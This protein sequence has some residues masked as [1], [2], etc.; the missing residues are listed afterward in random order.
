MK[1]SYHMKGFLCLNL[2]CYLD[3]NSIDLV[4]SLLSNNL[5]ISTSLY[6]LSLT[7][8]WLFTT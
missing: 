2:S 1:C 4:D 6:P 5:S 8:Y 7:C 3:L